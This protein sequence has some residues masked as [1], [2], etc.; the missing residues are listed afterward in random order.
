MLSMA[1]QTWR[2][3][4]DNW[5][6]GMQDSSLAG[7]RTSLQHSIAAASVHT[8]N[9]RIRELLCLIFLLLV[10]GSTGIRVERQLD[11]WRTAVHFL[12]AFI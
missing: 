6:R 10:K 2:E 3:R 8:E 11:E 9:P 4:D 7:G 5:K 1:C 12:S